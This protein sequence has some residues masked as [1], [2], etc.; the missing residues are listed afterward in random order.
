MM[1]RG[2]KH[3]RWAIPLGVVALTVVSILNS[4]E[5]REEMGAVTGLTSKM[6]SVCVGRFLV[7]VPVD[8]RVSL[9]LASV[10]GFE[11]GRVDESTDLFL[12]RL[13][14]R[15]SI[16]GAKP[17]MFGNGNIESSMEIRHARFYGKV[18]VHSRYRGYSVENDQRVYFETISAEGHVHKE[19]VSYRFVANVY[20]PAQVKVIPALLTRLTN[21]AEAELPT[22]SG[23]CIGGA[24]IRDPH[25]RDR[26]E[27][28]AMSANPPGHPDLGILFWTNNAKIKGR[29]LLERHRAAMTPLTRARARTLREGIRT[30]NGCAGEEVAI[31]VTEL[32]F[33][34]VFG[35]AWE[36]PGSD[37]N[38]F[39]PHLSLEMDSG[40]SPRAGGKP[41]QS[42]PSEAAMRA[43]WDKIS[44]SVRLRPTHHVNTP[45]TDAPLALPGPSP[46]V[47]DGKGGQVANLD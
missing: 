12:S 32:N 36:T 5:R 44:S 34:K 33:A 41:V 2:W 37:R 16:L 42:S 14:T 26:S 23:F 22:E 17:N 35:F 46:T 28:I 31:K 47:A 29:T 4:V 3:G 43:L 8:A 18:F 13:R 40:M 7:D 19:G 15:E 38:V 39:V 21:R 30:I 9:Q 11:L 10:D 45:R 25:D 6:K 1:S 24:M 27:N 20:D